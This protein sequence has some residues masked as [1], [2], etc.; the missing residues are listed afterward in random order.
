MQ[1]VRYPDGV[2][3]FRLYQKRVPVPHPVWLETV[4]DAFPPAAPSRL[5]SRP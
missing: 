2:D 3:G 5:T 4:Q 1:L